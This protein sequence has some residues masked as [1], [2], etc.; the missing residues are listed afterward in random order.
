MDCSNQPIFALKK[1]LQFRFPNMFQNYFP[2]F[3]GLHIEQCLPVLH[4][5]LVKGSGLMEI[6]H[7]QNL[8][9]VG[10][11]AVVDVSSIKRTT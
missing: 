10:L 4:G 6:L 11:S 3:G 9:T 1:E 7:F 2:L 5:Q 8:S